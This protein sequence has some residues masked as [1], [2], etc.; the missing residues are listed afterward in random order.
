MPVKNETIRKLIDEILSDSIDQKE[1]DALSFFLYPHTSKY[2]RMY[3]NDPD[4]V[5]GDED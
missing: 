2:K 5:F 3:S 1:I 4:V